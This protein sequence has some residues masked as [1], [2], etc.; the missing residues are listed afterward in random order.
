MTEHFI[1]RVRA[2]GKITIPKELRKLLTINQ[3]DLVTLTIKKPEWWELLDWTEMG[4]EAFNR[5][6]EET[7]Q[8]IRNLTK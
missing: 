5:L 6:P 2:E 4:P 8:K 7:Q 1:A 3:G